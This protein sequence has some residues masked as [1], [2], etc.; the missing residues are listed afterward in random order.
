M[1]LCFTWMV[2]HSLYEL[3]IHQGNMEMRTA[4]AYESKK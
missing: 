2:R 4:A 3:N 1:V